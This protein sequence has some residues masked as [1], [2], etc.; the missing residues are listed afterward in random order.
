MRL[1]RWQWPPGPSRPNGDELKF[2]TLLVV[3]ACLAAAAME[4]C[5]GIH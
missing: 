2:T 5:S 1:W 4:V 3:L